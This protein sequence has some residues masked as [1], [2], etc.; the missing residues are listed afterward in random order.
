[1]LTAGPLA[2]SSFRS[3]AGVTAAADAD[4]YLIYDTTSGALYYDAS[5]NAGAAPVHIASLAA[6]LALSNLDFVIT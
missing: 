2:A 3:G 1:L 5:G 4:D 6:G